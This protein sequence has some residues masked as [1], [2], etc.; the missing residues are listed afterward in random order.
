MR[1]RFHPRCRPRSPQAPVIAAKALKK[2][3]IETI[4]QVA[5]MHCKL[6]KGK[7]AACCTRHILQRHTL[8]PEHGLRHTRA[9]ML[10][11]LPQAQIDEAFSKVSGPDHRVTESQ[12]NS[13]INALLAQAKP[14]DSVAVRAAG[15]TI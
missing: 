8:V 7:H 14:S 12:I 1:Q 13:L 4:S 9:G 10:C 15:E 5:R 11:F 6:G 3:H 2:A